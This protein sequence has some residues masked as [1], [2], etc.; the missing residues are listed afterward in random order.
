[1]RRDRPSVKAHRY[2]GGASHLLTARLLVR[3]EEG[4]LG[5]M[6]RL[7]F[8]ALMVLPA[9]GVPAGRVVHH[10]LQV[11]LE[12]S[13][14]HIEVRDLITLPPD[15]ARQ[16]V[17]F[18][19]ARSLGLQSDTASVA[20]M[21][22][23]EARG[24]TSR[25]RL[26]L[27]A[28]QRRVE[29]RYQG[30]VTM[31]G[32]AGPGAD[33]PVTG[34]VGPE[35]VYLDAESGWYPVFDDAMVT[36]KLRIKVPN[37]WRTMSQGQPQL[38]AA[39]GE[40]G[41]IETHPQDDIYLVAAPFHAYRRQGEW[42][43]AMV[44][45]REQDDAL[46]R[47]YLD[48]T[49]LYLDLYSRLIAPYPYAKFA[50]VENLWETGYGMP[51]FTLLG[52]SVIRLPFIL[53]SS[54]PHEILHNWWGNSVYID[55]RSGNWAEGLTSYLAD[56]LIAEQRGQG[57]AYRRS[58]LQKYADY[59]DSA[60]DF[61]LSA[62]RAKHGDLTQAVGYSKGLMFFHM[63]RLQLGDPV[64]LEGL[65]RFYR[66]NVFGVAGFNALRQAFEQE[67]GQDLEAIFEQWLQRTGAP[68]L[69]LRDVA[70]HAGEGGYH[71]IGRLEQVQAG[72]PYRLL[73]PVAVQVE[74]ADT[75]FQDRLVMTGKRLE[76]DLEVPGPPLRLTVDPQ[77][78]VFRRLDRA[79]L[80]PSFGAVFG[81]PRLTIVL[82]ASAPKALGDA[83]RAVAEQWAK[84]VPDAEIVDDAKLEELPEGRSVWLFGWQNRFTGA[85]AE[86]L[87]AQGVEI[88]ATELRLPEKAL[89]RD[90]FSVV[91]AAR[92]PRHGEQN[93]AWLAATGAN[94]L[95][96]L[97]R[98]LPH[99]GK[100]SYLAFTGDGPDNVV[101]GQWPVLDSPLSAAL[102]GSGEHA[103]PPH[104]GPRPALT[105]L[106]H[107]PG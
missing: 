25:Y 99:Y 45:L 97:A 78:D 101:K 3:A 83:Y 4:G 49:G 51:S 44:L 84:R 21:E 76:F 10:D 14:G 50:L 31:P 94:A 12:P 59:V 7:V 33:H 22:P 54:Y 32:R 85:I 88:L 17:T 77:F 74:G 89:P 23:V 93:L 106:L 28:G 19:L 61:P 57:A 29:L 70:A 75:A 40:D 5:F 52:P 6:V 90:T 102:S 1:M 46:A 79:E 9:T 72:P 105:A 48:A 56:H 87:G 92:S 104:L 68:Q 63:L 36:F 91:L 2:R 71:V 86:A 41:W 43:Q 18:S 60:R 103:A 13:L 96:G 35:G 55:Y 53:H 30:Q 107:P 98:K 65:R 37:G 11:V 15:L 16:A 47:R 34:F 39:Q 42:A 69:A 64:F 81:A 38:P 95:P 100:Y 80:P 67:S 24:S 62:F 8:V 26:D 66:D 73:V 82:P 27:A 58:A 20:A